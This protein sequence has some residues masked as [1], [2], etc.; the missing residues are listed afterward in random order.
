MQNCMQ[1]IP[2]KSYNTYGTVVLTLF[3]L[4]AVTLIGITSEMNA[5]FNLR[6]NLGKNLAVDINS[7]KTFVETTCS[8]KY[9]QKYNSPVPFNWFVILNFGLVF[10]LSIIYAFSVKSRVEK[11]DKPSTTA[12]DVLVERQPLSQQNQRSQPNEEDTKFRLPVFYIYLLHLVF[13]RLLPMVLFVVFVFYPANFPTKF[14]CPW[15]S[16]ISSNANITNITKRFNFS[17]VDCKNPLGSKSTSLARTV[18][19]VD[20]IFSLVTLVEAV[21]LV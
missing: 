4:T 19:I 2:R 20:I 7:Q 18:W 14:S 13:F 5:N 12:A 6:C 17:T 21:Y 1:I 8:L 11:L 9:E 10:A 15:P 3:F 16:G